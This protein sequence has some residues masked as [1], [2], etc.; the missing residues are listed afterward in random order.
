MEFKAHRSTLSKALARAAAASADKSPISSLKCVLIVADKSGKLTLRGTNLEQS[1]TVNTTADVK[2][3]GSVAVPAR[4][5][6][7]LIAKPLGPDVSIKVDGASII[8]KSSS[9][10]AK[11][12]CIPADD[13]VAIP[14]PATNA[15]KL[16]M[17]SAEL[18]RLLSQSSYAQSEDQS[19]TVMYA[20][21]LESDGKEVTSVAT[22]GYRVAISRFAVESAPLSE[23]I[24]ATATKMVQRFAAE[25]SDATVAV[26]VS[27]NEA[28][29]FLCFE[30]PDATLTLKRG[31][32]A[33]VPWRRVVP[34]SS[35]HRIRVPREALIGAIQVAMTAADVAATKKRS[36][37]I[38]LDEGKLRVSAKSADRGE[39]SSE[40]DVDYTGKPWE[41]GFGAEY[42]LQALASITDDDVLFCV[43]GE[44][45]PLVLVGA[46][47]EK[48]CMACV[49]PMRL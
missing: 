10:R 7:D 2:K 45:E 31:E 14:E 11:I 38:S 5:L 24:P 4:Q 44:L 39:A 20:T 32:Q 47:D 27:G 12:P 30:W 19:R 17:P 28:A 9:S 36:L 48:S 8:V 35:A 29:S 21:R 22:D 13:F 43:S 34:S 42:V 25:F 16:E 37:A 18:A 46:A 49:S 40:L 33:F 23:S 26:S 15:P 41:T 1:V 3:A 6:S